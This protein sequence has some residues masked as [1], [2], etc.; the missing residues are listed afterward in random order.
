[1]GYLCYSVAARR[2]WLPALD[3]AVLLAVLF[4]T[5]L[6]DLVDKPLAWYIGVLAS[7]RSLGHSLLFVVAVGAL[8]FWACSRFD[9]PE[10]A[11]GLV[12]GALSHALVDTLPVLWNPDAIWEFLFYPVLNE[13][14]HSSE[15]YTVLGLLRGSATDPYFL[16]EHLLFVA[17]VV[18]WHLEGA[19]GTGWLRSLRERTSPSAGT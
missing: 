17:A 18:R 4:G 10:L 13:Y 9:R 14:T 7:G 2:G 15:T 16:F 12:V 19:P 1:M 5:Q 11:L 8:A 6:P 3:D